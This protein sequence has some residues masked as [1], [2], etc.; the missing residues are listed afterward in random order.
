MTVNGVGGTEAET[1]LTMTIMDDTPTF[2]QIDNVIVANEEG[3]L[4][5][6]HDLS[7]GADG[8]YQINLSALTNIVG[9]NYS[10]PI[11]NSDGST[12][13][14]AGTG[15][16]PDS[17]LITDGVFELTINPDGTYTFDLLD[18]RPTV[19]NVVDFSDTPITGGSSDTTLALATDSGAVLFVGGDEDEPIV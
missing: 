8:E 10:D 2:T 1:T 15:T 4:L 17:S 9:L 18:A 5:G 13:I 6:T 12:T 11:Y 19:E 3:V 14:T 16:N 7:F